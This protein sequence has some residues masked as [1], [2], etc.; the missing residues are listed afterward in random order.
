MPSSCRDPSKEQ[1]SCLECWTSAVEVCI[2][3]HSTS[4]SPQD[5][6][7]LML[8]ADVYRDGLIVSKRMDILLGDAKHGKGIYLVKK[9]SRF[10]VLFFLQ[11]LKF[12]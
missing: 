4:S 11:R 10:M 8:Q 3:R 7:L 1:S 12:S 5:D 2:L 9:L 6:S